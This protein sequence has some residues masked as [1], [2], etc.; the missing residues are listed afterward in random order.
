L[1]LTVKILDRA[2]KELSRLGQTEARRIV[3]YLTERVAPLDDPTAIGKILAGNL[4]SLWRYRVGDYR[5]ICRLVYQED[6]HIV[7]VLAIGHRRE[8][9]KL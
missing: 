1:A 9:Y 6:M 7:E 4:A 8:I 2:K 5:I 3:N